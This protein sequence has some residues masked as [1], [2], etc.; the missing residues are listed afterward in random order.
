MP[1]AE[2][3]EFIDSLR[4]SQQSKSDMAR[5]MTV[6]KLLDFLRTR[7]CWHVDGLQEGG[8]GRKENGKQLETPTSIPRDHDMGLS[9]DDSSPSAAFPVAPCVSL[10]RSPSATAD[11]EP[12]VKRRKSSHDSSSS[13]ADTMRQ[14]ASNPST[15][16]SSIM[17][18]DLEPSTVDQDDV[19]PV[20]KLASIMDY[21]PY[22]PAKGVKIGPTAEMVML[23]AWQQASQKL[24]ECGCQ[25]CAR[26]DRFDDLQR[27]MDEALGEEDF[28]I[29]ENDCE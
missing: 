14:S 18:L 24:H 22:I 3:V 26:R 28:S 13:S 11:A 1:L 27:Q 7:E 5:Q 9:L 21:V 6:E 2:I 20:S 4:I 25:I 8:K 29:Y 16:P 19:D 10:K 12:D 15:A 17:S 23:S